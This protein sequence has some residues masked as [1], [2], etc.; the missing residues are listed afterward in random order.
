MVGD[1]VGDC[2]IQDGDGGGGA[3]RQSIRLDPTLEKVAMVVMEE[4]RI[5]RRFEASLS[6]RSG[7]QQAGHPECRVAQPGPIE[8]ADFGHSTTSRQEQ[9]KKTIKDKKLVA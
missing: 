3:A 9:K 4:K 8:A 6:P 7:D 1:G 2:G 5:Q